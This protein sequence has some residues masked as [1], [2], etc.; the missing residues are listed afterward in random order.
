[1]DTLIVTETFFNILLK[2]ILSVTLLDAE[3]LLLKLRFLTPFTLE[4]LLSSLGFITS[5][6]IAIVRL[7][8]GDP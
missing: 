7:S 4:T 5:I 2:I 1:M 6:V 8:L 3:Q